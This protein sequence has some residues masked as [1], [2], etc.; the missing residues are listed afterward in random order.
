MSNYDHDQDLYDY[1]DDERFYEETVA[2]LVALISAF[3]AWALR[4]DFALMVTAFLSLFSAMPSLFI[5]IELP[6]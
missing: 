2:P 1:D 6:F 4:S 5:T 3:I